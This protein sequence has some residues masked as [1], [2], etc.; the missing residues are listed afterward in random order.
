MKQED[1][2][3]PIDFAARWGQLRSYAASQPT[4]ITKNLWAELQ[5]YAHRV[6]L[7]EL[8]DIDYYLICNEDADLTDEFRDY[9]HHLNEQASL[10][11]N[12]L[13]ESLRNRYVRLS[14]IEV[15]LKEN[16]NNPGSFV[17]FSQLAFYRTMRKIEY[18]GASFE[19]GIYLQWNHR[20][21]AKG[22]PSWEIHPQKY[23]TFTRF[24]TAMNQW[25]ELGSLVEFSWTDLCLKIMREPLTLKII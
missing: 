8:A 21:L 24:K 4:K 13:F 2:I 17:K 22:T 1:L 6:F 18:E 12:Y 23:P 15:W 7:P 9:I 25:V 20:F 16:P 5:A 14:E 11:D 19:V 10:A 3:K